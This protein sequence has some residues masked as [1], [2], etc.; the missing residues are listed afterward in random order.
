MQFWEPPQPVIVLLVQ[1]VLGLEFS[2]E[3]SGASEIS[4]WTLNNVLMNVEGIVL[5]IWTVI[6]GFMC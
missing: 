2:M 4:L 6:Q 5:K 3:N 1:I